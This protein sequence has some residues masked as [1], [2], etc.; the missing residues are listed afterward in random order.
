MMTSRTSRSELRRLRPARAGSSTTVPAGA[1]RSSRSFSTAA[2]LGS[3]FSASPGGEGDGEVLFHPS[4]EPHCFLVL[5]LSE[6]GHELS[7]RGGAEVLQRV[8]HRM[9]SGKK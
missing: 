2:I 8:E 1:R 6:A 3:R 4:E 5:L 9:G 7:A